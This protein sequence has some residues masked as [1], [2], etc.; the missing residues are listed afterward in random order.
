MYMH[1]TGPLNHTWSLWSH[2]TVSILQ[3]RKGKY[4]SAIT[5][6]VILTLSDEF[7]VTKPQQCG[8]LVWCFWFL[9]CLRNLLFPPSPPAQHLSWQQPCLHQATESPAVRREVMIILLTEN[10]LRAGRT[11]THSSD[12]LFILLECPQIGPLCFSY[13]DQRALHFSWFLQCPSK[14]INFSLPCFCTAMDEMKI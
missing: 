6:S 8:I 2:T 10:L 7:I 11:W 12:L 3:V 5:V 4:T 14:M 9:L 13:M 1:K